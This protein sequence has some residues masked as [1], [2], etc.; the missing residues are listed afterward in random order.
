MG[1]IATVERDEIKETRLSLKR[2]IAGF[3]YRPRQWELAKEMKISETVLSTFLNRPEKPVSD[4]ILGRINRF[5]EKK[6]GGK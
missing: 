6:L 5:L 4:L 2:Y 3:T 1:L